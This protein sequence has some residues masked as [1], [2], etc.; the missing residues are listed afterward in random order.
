MNLNENNNMHLNMHTG[1]V[2]QTQNHGGH[3]VFDVTEILAGTLN[4]LNTYAICKNQVKDPE[5]MEIVNRQEQFIIQEYNTTL[6]CFQSGAD[7]KVPTQSYSMNQGNDFV[8]GLT[9]SAPKMPLQGGG[10]LDDEAISRMLL[11]NMKACATTK[12]TAALEVTNP[13]VRRVLSDS[14]PNCI[15]MA[16][17]L[18]HYQ[19]K[20]HYYQVPQLVADDMNQV[21]NGYAAINPQTF[22]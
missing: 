9:P 16:Y 7:P 10:Q 2:P 4:T 12:A 13:V 14:V 15:E 20:H 17:E 5:L 21:I 3:E 6:D 22:Q 18:S 19:N 11:G 1:N 8:Y